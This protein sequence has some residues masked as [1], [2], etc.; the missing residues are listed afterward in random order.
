M[1]WHNSKD[2]LKTSSSG[3][4]FTALAN[5][6]F[7]KGGVVVGAA[8]QYGEWRVY[9]ACA[10]HESE[11][12]PLKLSK[13][14]QSDMG[15]TYVSVKSYLEKGRMVL[16]PEPPVRWPVCRHFCAPPALPWKRFSQ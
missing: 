12:E 3:G 16:F 6:T 2:V 7:S 5:Y 13:Y 1:G 10:E 9:H 4:I 15:N 8:K 14:V 11:L